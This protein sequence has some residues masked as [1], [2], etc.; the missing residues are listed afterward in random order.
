MRRRALALAAVA[1]CG[2]CYEFTGPGAAPDLRL[3]GAWA[4]APVTPGGGGVY[5]DLH[6]A[7][8]IITGTGREY[9]F[10]CLYDTF[11][12]TGEY[13]DISRSFALLIRY[14]RGS[15]GT[16]AGQVFG[17]DSLKDTWTGGN[18]MTWFP[19]TFYRA[20]VPPCSDSVPLSG[21]Y[22]PAAPG[23]IV[24]FQD[25]VNATAEAARLGALYDFT[26][27]HVYTVAPKGFSA[28]IPMSTVT[29]LRCEPKV[30][31]IEYDGIVTIAE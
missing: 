16:F 12:A 7:G 18:S 27:T 25:S 15:S 6:A 23:F 4:F 20:L 22:D 21:T 13:S 19:S 8:G 31:S 1:L 26:P 28:D 29:V 14:S 3:T 9:H 5:L 24:L 10:C 30:L 11:T 2:A 17:A